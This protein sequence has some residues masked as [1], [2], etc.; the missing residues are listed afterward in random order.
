MTSIG[1]LAAMAFERY[2]VCHYFTHRHLRIKTKYY[3][4]ISTWIYGFVLTFPPLC[5]WGRY[6]LDIYRPSCTYDYYSHDLNSQTFMAFLVVGGFFLPALIIIFCYVSM[7]KM[8]LSNEKT[9]EHLA[10]RPSV[11][12]HSS[13]HSN[14]EE[15]KPKLHQCSSLMS[16]E[17]LVSGRRHSSALAVPPSA[18]SVPLTHRHSLSLNDMLFHGPQQ[19]C[20]AILALA[21]A[22]ELPP[23]STIPKILSWSGQRNMSRT[24]IQFV[25]LTLMVISAFFICWTPYA[26]LTILC[27]FRVNAAFS[28]TAAAI[29]LLFAKSSVALNP[30]IYAFKEKKFR[31]EVTSLLSMIAGKL[32]ASLY[33]FVQLILH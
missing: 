9:M 7:F 27:Q 15:A 17:L 28:P 14:K 31:L 6:V 3:M 4:I 12:S 22:S 1:S 2:T 33:S 8:I 25:K 19:H 26:I 29:T 5:G 23:A 13:N 30:I 20:D 32:R 11:K 18:M 21:A 16:P 10:L 24:E